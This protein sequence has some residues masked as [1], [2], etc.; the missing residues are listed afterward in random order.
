MGKRQA[1]GMTFKIDAYYEQLAP[2]GKGS[3]G[4]VVYVDMILISL[5]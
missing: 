3:Y 5:L 1:Y 2:L 4:I